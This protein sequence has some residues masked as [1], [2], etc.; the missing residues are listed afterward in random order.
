[1][2]TIKKVFPKS[3]EHRPTGLGSS[4]KLIYLIEDIIK[5]YDND[6]IW[7]TKMLYLSRSTTFVREGVRV[8]GALRGGGTFSEHR[9]YNVE[10]K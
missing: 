5:I 8:W 9:E 1:M 4:L 10:V 2:V 6:Y 7:S 3:S